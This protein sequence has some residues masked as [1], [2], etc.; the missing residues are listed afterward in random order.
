MLETGAGHS[1]NLHSVFVSRWKRVD[2]VDHGCRDKN[3]SVEITR[4][5]AA[6]VVPV[7]LARL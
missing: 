2:R 4:G 1:H 3:P 5:K 6:V 7:A